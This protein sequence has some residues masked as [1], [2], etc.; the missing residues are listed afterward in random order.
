MNIPSLKSVFKLAQVLSIPENGAFGD[1]LA[2]GLL[3]TFLCYNPKNSQSDCLNEF[4]PLIS[5]LCHRFRELLP[6]NIRLEY[7]YK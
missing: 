2:N 4:G 5:L 7:E 6:V 3:E 1:I